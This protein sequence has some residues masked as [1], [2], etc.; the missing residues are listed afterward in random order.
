MIASPLRHPAFRALWIAATVSFVG[1]FVQDVA[2]RW[3]ILDLTN[4][5]MSAAMLATTFVGVSLVAMLPA[6]VLADRADRSLLVAASQLAQAAVA[7]AIAIAT[8]TKHVTPAVLLCGAAAAGLAVA[9]GSPAWSALVSEILPQREVAEGVTLNAIAFN[10]ARAVGPAIGG[11]VLGALGAGW[12]FFLNALTFVF[13]VVAVLVHRPVDRPP[14]SQPPPPMARAFLEPFAHAMREIGVRAVIGSMLFFTLGAA[15][16]YA[17]APAFAK[18][19][20]EAD[21]RA[22]GLMIGAMGVGA[23]IGGA[24]MKPLRPFLAPRTLLATTMAIYG[25]SSI[26]LARAHSVTVAI[27]L[28]VP[29]GVGWTATFSSLAA[30]VQI[31]VPNRM[32]A[33]LLAVYTMGHFAFW[34]IGSTVG[35]ALAEHFDVRVSFLAGGITAV[36]AGLV[37]ARLPLPSSFHGATSS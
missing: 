8:W 22:Y 4:S 23:V 31:W 10:L 20:L 16:V 17:L 30:L 6:G 15:S 24:A 25:L 5:P 9:L 1:T 33:R 19:T 11:V 12:S 29:A 35:G 37:T 26:A 3:L 18:L 13:V 27:V 28:F 14:P 21:P 36:A 7:A 32:R 34:G 2:E